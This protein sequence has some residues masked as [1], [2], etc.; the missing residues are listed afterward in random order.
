MR[1]AVQADFAFMNPGGIRDRLP[2]GTIL[3]RHMWNIMPFDNRV[4]VADLPG[5]SVPAAV[6]GNRTVQPGRRYTLALPDY[7]AEN[8]SERASLGLAPF[9]FRKTDLTVRDAL[10]NWTKKRKVLD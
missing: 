8:E 1:D 5:S 6:L 10:I 2:K 4:L 7:V 9:E 3:A